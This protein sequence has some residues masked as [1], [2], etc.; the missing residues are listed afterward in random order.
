MRTGGLHRARQGPRRAA[1]AGHPRRLMAR[2]R[3][4]RTPFHRARGRR[5]R[6][7]RARHPDDPRPRRHLE[8]LDPVLRAESGIERSGG[9]T[10]RAARTAW[11][12]ADDRYASWRRCS[13]C[14]P[15]CSRPRARPRALPRHIVASTSRPLRRDCEGLGHLRSLRPARPTRRASIRARAPR[16][17][18]TR[19]RR[20]CNESPI[21]CSPPPDSGGGNADAAAGRRWPRSVELLML[22]VPR[23]GYRTYLRGARR[24]QPA[25]MGGITARPPRHRRRGHGVPGPVVRQLGGR[26]SPGRRVEVQARSAAHWNPNEK[27]AECRTC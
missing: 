9:S 5:V 3:A 14:A 26:I 19:A 10:A 7:R 4:C 1:V 23:D 25:E 18:G 6:R 13:A 12:I 22:P 17:R 21:P 8:C 24:P 15:H 11:R 20:A 16:R 2:I 27:P